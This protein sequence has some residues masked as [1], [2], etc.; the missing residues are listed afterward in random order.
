MGTFKALKIAE[1]TTFPGKMLSFGKDM[2]MLGAFSFNR[3]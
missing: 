3:F 1:M 2:G